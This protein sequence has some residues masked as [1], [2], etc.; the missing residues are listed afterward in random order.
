MNN[1]TP[2]RIREDCIIWLTFE[3]VE[4]E[5]FGVFVGAQ[6]HARIPNKRRC[7]YR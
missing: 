3:Q 6:Q 4:K 7:S 1:L 5:V 2:V